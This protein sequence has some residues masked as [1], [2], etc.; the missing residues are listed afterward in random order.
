MGGDIEIYKEIRMGP[1]RAIG[2]LFGGQGQSFF[3]EREIEVQQ[4]RPVK[5]QEILFAPLRIAAELEAANG[6][7]GV[8]LDLHGGLE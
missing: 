6:K 8:A 4:K 2:R 3:D 7:V 5:K 1:V